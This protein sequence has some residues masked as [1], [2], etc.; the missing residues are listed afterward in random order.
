MRIVLGSMLMLGLAVAPMLA[1]APPTLPRQAPE[2]QINMPGGKQPL[3]LSNYRGKVVLIAFIWTT[4]IHCQ[5][6]T[7][8][9]VK[10]NQDLGPSGLQIIE[11]AINDMASM[12]VPDFVRDFHVNFPVGYSDLYPA[13]QWL[14]INPTFRWGVPQVAIID[15]KGVIR[16]QTTSMSD[17][18]FQEESTLRAM[19]EPLLKEGATTSTRHH[20]TTASAKKGS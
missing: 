19:L 8:N 9:F 17:D 4:C 18:K 11:V 16:Y 6:A 3:L 13:L 1:Q 7:G 12:L 15:R 14:Q 5:H 20:S 2:F 10:L